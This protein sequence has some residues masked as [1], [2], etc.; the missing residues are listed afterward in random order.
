M[1]EICKNCGWYVPA[2]YEC[3]NSDS[4]RFE[5]GVEDNDTCGHFVD[6]D[7]IEDPNYEEVT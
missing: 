6:A 7:D 1:K 5:D 3:H 2:L 4:P